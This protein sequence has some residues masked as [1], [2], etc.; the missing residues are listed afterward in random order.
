MDLVT[1]GQ[2][3]TNIVFC[4]IFQIEILSVHLCGPSIQGLNDECGGKRHIIAV[5]LKVTF[6]IDIFNF[7]T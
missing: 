5:F 1:N 3:S 4:L 6:I 2:I 7:I